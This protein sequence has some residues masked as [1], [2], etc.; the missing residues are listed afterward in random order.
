MSS[1]KGKRTPNL[2]N[3]PTIIV[4][5]GLP[6]RGKTYISKKLARYLNWVGVRTKVFNVGNYRRHECKNFRD[7]DFFRPDN[8]HAMKIRSKCASEALKDVFKWLSGDGQIAVYD[9]TNTTRDRR[10][11]IQNFAKENDFKVFFIESLCDNPKVIEQNITEV[12]LNGPDYKGLD[13][14]QAKIDFE[15]RIEHYKMAYETL[16]EVLDKELSFIKVIDVGERFMVNRVSDH[17]QVCDYFKLRKQ[18]LC[19]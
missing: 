18:S 14:N 11:K 5:V 4:M 6:A 3:V 17:I 15:L 1:S 10:N 8:E 16:D 13:P 9:A 12:K 2:C 19:M 7:H